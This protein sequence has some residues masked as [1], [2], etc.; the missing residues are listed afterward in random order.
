MK[1]LFLLCLPLAAFGQQMEQVRIGALPTTASDGRSCNFVDV[2]GDGWDDIF[3]SNGKKGGQNNMLFRND[4]QGGFVRVEQ[5]PIVQDNSPSDGAAFADVDND[6]DLDAFVVTWYGV[7]NFFYVNNGNGAFALRPQPGAEGT[8]SETAAW[9]DYDQ[10]GLVDLYVTNSSDF[11]TNS[12]AVKRNQLHHNLGQDGFQRI[13]TGAAVTDADISRSVNW[14]DYDGDGDLDLFVTNEENQRNRLYRNDGGGLLTAVAD[15]PFVKD[16]RTTMSSSWADIDNDGD[17]DLF[18]ANFNNQRNQ[19]F[20]NEGSSF[21]EI[22]TG[23]LVSRAGYHFSSAFA[24]ADNDGDLDLFVTQGYAPGATRNLF[25]RNDGTGSFQL[26][27]S[28]FPDLTTSCA[29]GCAWGDIDNDGFPDLVVATCTKDGQSDQ[30]NLLYHNTGNDNNWLKIRLVGNPSNRAGIGAKVRLYA[31]LDGKSVTQLRE[32]SSQDGYCSQ[33]SLTA[34]FGLADAERYDSLR[35]DWPSGRVTRLSSG[36][37]GE[38]LTLEEQGPA[39]LSPSISGGGQLRLWPVPARDTLWLSL[40]GKPVSAEMRLVNAQGKNVYARQVQLG[41]VATVF[42]T[43]G[44][45]E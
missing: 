45:H 36:A 43:R 2:N 17:L 5:D 28:F 18:L 14:T 20:L 40:T 31:T 35:V 11:A 13:T 24:D 8:F 27:E 12:A 1:W 25:Y 23:D 9:G 32:L 3:I 6:G 7:R 30:P 26:D 19:L 16:Q 22:E 41:A 21:T 44:L 15:L 10:D 4:Q 42:T 38:I 29:Y 33:N 37:A 34:H 39:A